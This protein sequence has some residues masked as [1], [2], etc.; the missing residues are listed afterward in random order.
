MGVHDFCD[1]VT[2]TTYKAF[3]CSAVYLVDCFAKRYTVTYLCKSHHGIC[4]SVSCLQ[5]SNGWRDSD[6]QHGL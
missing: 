1:G 5:S 6:L 4:K 3:A 2:F